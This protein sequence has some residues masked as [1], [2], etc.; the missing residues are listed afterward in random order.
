MKETVILLDNFCQYLWKKME[1][2]GWQRNTI[3]LFTVY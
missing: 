3:L 2:Y 1:I